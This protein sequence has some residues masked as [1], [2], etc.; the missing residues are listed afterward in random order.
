MSGSIAIHQ[1]IRSALSEGRPVVALETAVVTHGLPRSPIATTPRIVGDAGEH[2]TRARRHCWNEGEAPRAWQA[3]APLNLEVARLIE[4][5][6]RDQGAVPATTAVIEGTLHIGLEADQLE[7]LATAEEV[8]KCSAR[9][10]ARTM[11]ESG[12]GGTTV[13]GTLATV[14][15]ANHILAGDGLPRI[16]VFATGGIGGVHRNWSRHGDVSADL[17]ALAVTP[18]AVISAG[19]KVILDLPATREALDTNMVPV[20]G[21]RTDR[22]PMFTAQGVPDERPLPRFDDI[23]DV[24]S[25]CRAHWDTLG[26]PEGVLLANEIPDGMG[27][28]SNHLETLVLEAVAEAD[29]AGIV[30][31]A[32]TPYLL[33]RLADTSGGD[34]LDANITLLCS[35]A[36][37]AGRLSSAL[38]N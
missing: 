36:S 37:L 6:V 33:G 30:G 8:T 20:F 1:E 2:A 15:A 25:T 11:A 29:A 10:L 5:T 34:A 22:F 19:A 7:R 32:L 38:G 27:L 31:A 16:E 18:I 26:R 9:D 35:N 24:A 17:R 4:A 28:D 12:S 23:A 21:W 14:Q 13:A 3:D